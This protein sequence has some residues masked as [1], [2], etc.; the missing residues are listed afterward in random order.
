MRRLY[1]RIKQALVDASEGDTRLMFRTMNNI[2][3]VLRNVI[4][5]EVLVTERQPGGCKFE[6]IRH[7]VAVAVAAMRCVP[8]KSMAALWRLVRWSAKISAEMSAEI[9]QET[10]KTE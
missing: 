7:L 1:T 10:S 9:A 4:S 8:A 3:R 6:D 2:T 5:E